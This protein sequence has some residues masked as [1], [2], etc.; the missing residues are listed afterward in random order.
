VP[1]K[2]S[3]E[4]AHRDVEQK[5]CK[6]ITSTMHGKINNKR[7]ASPDNMEIQARLGQKLRILYQDLVDEPIPKTFLKLLNE[8]EKWER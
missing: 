2:G 6:K 5:A 7:V 8:L 1:K 3:L 4:G